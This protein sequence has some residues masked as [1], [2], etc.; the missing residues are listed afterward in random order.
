M[1]SK[2]LHFFYHKKVRKTSISNHTTKIFSLTALAL[3]LDG[4]NSSFLSP[5]DSRWH[6]SNM[7]IFERSCFGGADVGLESISGGSEL[8]VGEIC[9][10]ID[11]Q[12]VRFV[13]GLVERFYTCHIILEY[14]VALAF[15]ASILVYS[16]ILSHPILMSL[17]HWCL[18]KVAGFGMRCP[19][20]Q[21]EEQSQTDV[22]VLV[23]RSH[24]IGSSRDWWIKWVSR[25][26]HSGIAAGVYIGKSPSHIT[27]WSQI[28]LPWKT[29]N[30]LIYVPWKLKCC[31]LDSSPSATLFII[32]WLNYY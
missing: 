10:F 28:I 24:D 9:K 18:M 27:H 13:H 14:L 29:F 30:T 25:L 6:C 19:S 21:N 15:L 4:C 23:N 11:A 22:S 31:D 1:P 7:L 5:I 2:T 3:V 26:I 8:F 17:I 20:S 12:L 32:C 16:P